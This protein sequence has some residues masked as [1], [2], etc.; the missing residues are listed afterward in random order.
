MGW[1]ENQPIA[2]IVRMTREVALMEK[3]LKAETQK[4]RNGRRGF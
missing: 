4:M 3:E 2:K 1:L